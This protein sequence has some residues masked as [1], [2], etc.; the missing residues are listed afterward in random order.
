MTILDKYRHERDANGELTWLAIAIDAAEEAECDCG[1]GDPPCA[2]CACEEALIEVVEERE[3]A[4]GKLAKVRQELAAE[5][6]CDCG[7]CL[8]CRVADVVGA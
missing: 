3:A 5:P 8:A 4:R 6:E 7:T 2:I 1:G